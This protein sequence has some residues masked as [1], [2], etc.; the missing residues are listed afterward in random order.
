MSRRLAV[1]VRTWEIGVF[2]HDF[3]TGETWASPRFREM[4]GFGAD[5][6]VSM[7]EVARLVLP[8]DVPMVQAAMIEANRPDGSGVFD[9]LYRVIRKDGAVRWVHGRGATTFA[10]VDGKRVQLRTTGTILD[11]TEREELRMTAERDERRLTEAMAAS[12]VGIYDWD[13]DP[14][15]PE[16]EFF[17]S[18]HY[19]QMCGYDPD[20]VP[21]VDWYLGRIHADD[22]GRFSEAMKNTLDPAVRSAFDVE[23]RWL[24]PGG[25]TRWFVARSTTTFRRKGDEL[26]PHHTVGAV[27]DITS[28]MK[29]EEK[30]QRAQKMEVIG[31]LAGGIAH[32]FNNVLSVILGFSDLL[33]R[34][35]ADTD[36]GGTHVREIRF[37]V[38]RAASLTRQLLTISRK[39]LVQPR[40]IELN[41]LLQNALPMFRRLIDA[42]IDVE[43]VA[44][45]GP[46]LVKAD[47]SQF[48]QV[49]LNLVVNARDAMPQ[50]G[51]LRLEISHLEHRSD[52]PLPGLELEPGSY[53]VLTVSDSGHGMTPE[54]QERIFEPFFTTKD[55]G[56]GTG[57]GLSTVFDIVQ[58]WGGAIWLHSE[59]NR[60]TTFKIHVPATN[61]L[62]E[63]LVE[64]P[65]APV[66]HRGG[67]ILLVEDEPQLRGMLVSVLEQAGYRVL[68]AAGPVEALGLAIEFSERI[69]L[70]L[71]DVVMP[72]MTGPMLAT[73]LARRRPDTHVLFMSGYT[74]DAMVRRGLIDEKLNFLQKPVGVAVLLDKVGKLLESATTRVA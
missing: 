41:E 51:E 26:V 59:L 37:A 46:A 33:E 60:G 56:H 12:R 3:T 50:G 52:R 28:T 34:G 1:A 9:Q 29:L 39:E 48:E 31:R 10:E 63:P 21:D 53:V 54:V 17:W 32:D 11:V 44:S 2:E 55:A 65:S 7:I 14:A 36:P 69:D 4:L 13:H 16:E 42:T 66:S 20:A 57:L 19:R 22:I 18:P 25:E 24:H 30:L 38:E 23:Y 70:L 67:T 47:P 6:A 72:Q 8:A 15:R 27:L 71:T 45:E 68:Q 5:E 62:P 49:L 35:L 58:K 40:P 43:L 61:E 73:E 74:E 64:R